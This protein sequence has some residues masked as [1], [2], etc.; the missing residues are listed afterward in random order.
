MSLSSKLIDW[1]PRPFK[2]YDCW[3]LKKG[4][5]EVMKNEW[6]SYKMVGGVGFCFKSK[7]DCLKRFLRK[8]NKESFGNIEYTIKTLEEKLN[9]L[10]DIGDGRDM[11]KEEMEEKR[12]V[13]TELS[14]QLRFNESM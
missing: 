5:L 10:D 13:S 1:G 4:G 6:Q 9:V 3:L 14:N 11:D 8:W 12:A 2:F 7:L